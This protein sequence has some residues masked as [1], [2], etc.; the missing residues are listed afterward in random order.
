MQPQNTG[1]T[2]VAHS[3]HASVSALDTH[4]DHHCFLFVSLKHFFS[5]LLLSVL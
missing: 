1:V 5:L 4:L 2:G 3:I